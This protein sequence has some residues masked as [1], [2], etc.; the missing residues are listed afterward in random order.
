MSWVYVCLYIFFLQFFSRFFFLLLLLFYEKWEVKFNF[1]YIAS[2]RCC[3]RIT[4][5]LLHTNEFL[6]IMYRELNMVVTYVFDVVENHFHDPFIRIVIE[7]VQSAVQTNK[8]IYI[9]IKSFACLQVD[10][11]LFAHI[12]PT[13][14]DVV[15]D[16]K[17]HH[18]ASLE[19]KHKWHCEDTFAIWG[20]IVNNGMKNIVFWEFFSKSAYEYIHIVEYLIHLSCRRSFRLSADVLCIL[21]KEFSTCSC[22]PILMNI[23]TFDSSPPSNPLK[24][25]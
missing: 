23:F 15:I 18:S 12:T 22:S 5:F 14:V 21:S 19:W 13:H 7:K 24:L 2:V 16:K 20:L 3:S 10:W 1:I 9:D 8:Q 25:N 17:L 11:L 6:H 4:S